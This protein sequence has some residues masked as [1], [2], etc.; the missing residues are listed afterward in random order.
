MESRLGTGRKRPLIDVG[1]GENVIIRE[2]RGGRELIRR[3]SE[4]GFTPGSRI[5]V[6]VNSGG[7][8][9]VVIGNSRTAIGRGMAR[10]IF[11]S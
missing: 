5:R 1:R 6:V 10:K 7:P 2:I 4:M 9:I 3:L 11:V 8:V